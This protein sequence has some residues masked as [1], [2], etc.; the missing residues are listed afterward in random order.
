MAAEKGI[1]RSPRSA[2]RLLE[3]EDV[4][5]EQD[6]ALPVSWRRWTLVIQ[7]ARR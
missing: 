2:D 3:G 5:E 1:S 6:A 7:R 4:L